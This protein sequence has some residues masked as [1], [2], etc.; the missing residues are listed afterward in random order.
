MAN[1][2]RGPLP[3]GVYSGTLSVADVYPSHRGIGGIGTQDRALPAFA[4]RQIAAAESS[5]ALGAPMESSLIGQPAGWLL[6]AIAAL[7]V[8]GLVMK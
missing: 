1:A 3:L 4:E 8:A 6:L 7:L 2:D 5:T